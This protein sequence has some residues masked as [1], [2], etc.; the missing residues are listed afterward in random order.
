MRYNRIVRSC[1]ARE[2]E[3]S[4]AGEMGYNRIVRSCWARGLEYATPEKMRYNQFVCNG[5]WGLESAAG[6][7]DEGILKGESL[8]EEEG[9]A[10]VDEWVVDA[11]TVHYPQDQDRTHRPLGLCS[12]ML[13]VCPQ[14]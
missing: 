10:Q 2:L 8:E 11:R 13:A 4:A 9:G 5:A 7:L 6:F 12:G 3:Y 1:W 14:Y